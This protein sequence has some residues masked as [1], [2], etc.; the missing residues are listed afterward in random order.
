[1][2]LLIE[3]N[4][5]ISKEKVVKHADPERGVRVLERHKSPAKDPEEHALHS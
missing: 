5:D 3:A 2:C 1:M 4:S